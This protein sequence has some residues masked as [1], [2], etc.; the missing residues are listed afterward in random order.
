MVT[1]KTDPL[2]VEEEGHAATLLGNEAIVRGALEAGVGFASGY[3]GTPSSE[4]TDS[5]ARVAESRGIVFEYSVNEKI[6]LEMAFAASLAGTR[7]ICAMKHLG[8]MY[9]GDP[10]STIPYVGARGGLVIVS[11]G[12]PSCR[13]SPNEQ[14]QRY[15]AP[16]LGIPTLDPKTPLEAY[17]MARFAF[18]LSEQ[19]RL[20]VL[21]RPTTRVCHSRAPVT[22]GPLK[23]PK[24]SGFVRDPQ[25]LVPIPVNAR[26]MRLDQ[27]RRLALAARLLDDTDFVRSSGGSA[28]EGIIAAGAPAATCGDLLQEYGLAQEIPLLSVGVVYPLAAEKIAVFLQGKE[29]VLVVEELAPY[30]EDQVLALCARLRLTVEVLGKN[31]GHLPVPFEYE[32][33]LLRR[34]LH[35]ALGL[36]E[37]P[38]PRPAPP[39]VPVRPP[40]L[41]SSCPHRASYFVVRSVFGPE[42]LFFND[43]GC[44]TLGYGQPL[45]S[46]D[47]LLCM[48]AGVTLAAGVS[49]V[50]GERT[51]GFIGDSTFFHSGMPA[52]VNAIKEDVSM[53]VVVLDNQVTAMT[54]FQESP[55]VEAAGGKPIRRLSIEAAVRGLGTTQVEVTDPTDLPATMAALERARDA[56]GVSVVIMEHP[57]PMYMGRI[58]E[59]A[60]APLPFTVDH[61]RCQT[62]GR[63]PGGHRCGLPPERGLMRQMA[64][65]NAQRT[66]RA[67]HGAG[68]NPGEAPC[69]LQCPLFHCIQGYVGNIAAGNYAEA[70][71]LIL[72]RNPLPETVCRVCHRPCETACVREGVDQPVAI[73]DLKRFVMSWAN[74]Q[75][76]ADLPA[77][78]KPAEENGLS[79]AVV[80]A[81]PSGLA[82][83]HELR[84][85][86]Y[87]VT[88][89]DREQEPGG[90]LLTGIPEFRLPREA[91][92]RDIERVLA[93][94]VAFRGGVSLGVDFT[95]PELLAK[96]DAIY[97]AMGASRGVPLKLKTSQAL[98]PG[99]GP[100]V[101]DALTYLHQV[102]LGLP[103]ETGRRV[104][105]VGGGNAAIDAARTARRRGARQ[106]TIVYR[107]R[108]EEMPA[109]AHEIVAAETE[110]IVVRTQ[111]APAALEA[112]GLACVET[113]PG[114]PD[115]SGRCW[116]EPVPGS[117]AVVPAD[118]IILAIGQ[119]PEAF[120]LKAEGRGLD[121]EK[122]GCIQV[123]PSTGRTSHPRVFAGGDVVWG[124]RTVTWA[125]GAGQRAAWAMDRELRGEEA[126]AQ[127]M[128]PPRPDVNAER[129]EVAGFPSAQRLHPAELDPEVRVTSTAEVVGALSE[130]DARAEARRCLS[131]GMCGNCRAC[132]DLFGC[133]A[134][135]VQDGRVNIDPALCN[136]CGVC[137]H[138]CPNQA[139]GPAEQR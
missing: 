121:L 45:E 137:A 136:G 99:E 86:G 19:C 100:R 10:L 37:A 50:T 68:C 111:L 90:L 61:E 52:L 21:L 119:R 23:W 8:L 33:A 125:M 108:R 48:G 15:L 51:V 59:P 135:F 85:R 126:A 82:A 56:S 134:F 94:G 115:A 40:V 47:A 117:E 58:G 131:C 105:V 20:P 18:G 14:D 35:E 71:E 6:A 128:P 88:L 66:H 112:A 75:P 36:G 79:V 89:L 74:E 16:M 83:C 69:S 46:A 114:A 62:C 13:T 70:L 5:L 95:L 110:G 55:S 87:Q 63:E 127:R 17:R 3:P 57:C 101:V 27:E 123:T 78:P 22:F 118:Q 124:E 80:G 102:N 2:L 31:S 77:P 39:E 49:R 138:I 34:A 139:I 113:R 43:I 64:R 29:R 12:D 81:G 32:P 93:L 72:S 42:R 41:C 9:A 91:L 38:T 44:Y 4:I 107:R 98:A 76:A 84:L 26:P 67:D 106:I 65:A 73:N 97:L 92:R 28:I 103:M 132:I 7:A 129:L 1:K 130:A 120:S 122:D 104:A 133:P 25:G 60:P 54:G 11:A 24:V 30:L 96:H 53:V 116:P 109:I